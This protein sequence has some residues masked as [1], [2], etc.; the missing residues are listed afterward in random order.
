[1]K[2]NEE[3]IVRYLTSSKGKPRLLRLATNTVKDLPKIRCN[4]D[5]TCSLLLY[6]LFPPFQSASL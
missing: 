4:A 3:P 1:M 6:L 2:Q 5:G